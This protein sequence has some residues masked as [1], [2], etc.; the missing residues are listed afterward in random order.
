MGIG[1]SFASEDLTDVITDHL[2]DIGNLHDS[3]G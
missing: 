2:F 1:L 3:K